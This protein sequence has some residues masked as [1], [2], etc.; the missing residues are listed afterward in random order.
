MEDVHVA[1]VADICRLKPAIVDIQGMTDFMNRVVQKAGI[2][3]TIATPRLL[4][5][6]KSRRLTDRVSPSTRIQGATAKISGN[7]FDGPIFFALSRS[8][9]QKPYTTWPVQSV[10]KTY[11]S[12][13][14]SSC[15]CIKTTCISNAI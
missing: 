12:L 15:R 10:R 14:D 9:I 11:F 8:G 6:G 1:V 4:S 3:A 2:A 13:R 5:P 7:R